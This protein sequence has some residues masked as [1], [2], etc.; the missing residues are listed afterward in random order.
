ML[1]LADSFSNFWHEPRWTLIIALI[2]LSVIGAFRFHFDDDVRHMQSL[3]GGLVGEQ[4]LIEQ[5]IGN[6]AGAQFF[7]VQG[8]DEQI[9]LEREEELAA[10]L[11]PLLSKALVGLQS[12]A[13][14][15]P[16]VKRQKENWELVKKLYAEKLF[17]Q[18]KALNLKKKLI[19]PEGPKFLLPADIE[20]LNFL[21]VLK[22]DESAHVMMLDRVT[23]LSA[24]KAAS[25]GI[26]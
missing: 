24:V 11:R 5:L 4:Q 12:S 21:S 18:E 16:S 20:S 6:S 13:Q 9:I 23:D 8:A 25:N 3:S 1:K 14:Y 22:L 10:K 17:D 15:V 26:N 7:L 19:A 2:S